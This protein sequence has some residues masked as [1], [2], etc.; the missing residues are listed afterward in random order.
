MIAISGLNQTEIM[1]VQ[2]SKVKTH[3]NKRLANLH[4]SLLG[5][6][7]ACTVTLQLTFVNILIISKENSTISIN[8]RNCCDILKH[9]FQAMPVVFG[10]ETPE[11]AEHALEWTSLRKNYKAFKHYIIPEL[12]EQEGMPGYQQVQPCSSPSQWACKAHQQPC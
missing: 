11:I 3:I 4:C 1:L 8:Q 9:T 12:L 10:V 2:I 7:Q 5:H 6:K